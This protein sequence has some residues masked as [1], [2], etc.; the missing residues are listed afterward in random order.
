VKEGIK[1]SES[2]YQFNNLSP[3]ANIRNEVKRMFELDILNGKYV[4][5][6]RVPTISH[7]TKIYR[8]GESTAY[9]TLSSLVD[10]GIL[11]KKHGVGYFL[12]PCIYDKLMQSHVTELERQMREV[13]N[14]AIRIGLKTEEIYE[15]LKKIVS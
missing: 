2:A 9:K 8:V 3:N 12:K 7:F 14:Y 5:G 15:L 6:E 10:D 13:I 1:I 11:I 4:V